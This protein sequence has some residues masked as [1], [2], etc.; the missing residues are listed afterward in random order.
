MYGLQFP[1]KLDPEKLSLN[2]KSLELKPAGALRSDAEA[3]ALPVAVDVGVVGVVVPPP[4]PVL[5]VV[6]VV[7]P[8]PSPVLGIVGVVVPPPSPVVGIA[9]VVVP[10]PSPVVGIAGVVV[11]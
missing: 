11:P 7:V 2:T 6:G 9:G 3:G 4:S 1:S 8:P 5:G 10:P